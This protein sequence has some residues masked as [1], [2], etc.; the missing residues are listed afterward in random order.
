MRIYLTNLG[1]YN[2]GELI[3]LWL[4][5]PCTDEELQTALKQIGIGEHYEESF[6]IDYENDLGLTVYEYESLNELN[7]VA[8]CVESLSPNDLH[9][10]QAIIELESVNVSDIGWGR[11]LLATLLFLVFRVCV[12]Y[13]YDERWRDIWTNTAKYTGTKLST[14]H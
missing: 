1:K 8:K 13:N 5:L 7:E 12:R 4:K 11:C 14:K 2:E 6:I 9:L 10:L 3:G